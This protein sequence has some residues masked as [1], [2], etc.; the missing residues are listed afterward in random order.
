MPFVIVLAITWLAI[1]LGWY[2]VGIKMGVNTLP[3]I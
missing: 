1:I 2:L 3:T